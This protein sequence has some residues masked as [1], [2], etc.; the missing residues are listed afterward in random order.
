[1][2]WGQMFDEKKEDFK[3]SHDIIPFSHSAN[4]REVA[5]NQSFRGRNYAI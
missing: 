5:V 3:K 1:V 2:P 4:K